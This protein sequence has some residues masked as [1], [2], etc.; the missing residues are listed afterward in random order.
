[1]TTL[2]SIPLP[3]LDPV[4]AAGEVTPGWVYAVVVLGLFVVTFLLWLSMRKQLGRIRFTE[5][6]S[7]TKDDGEDRSESGP[8]T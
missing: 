3:L 4:P 5:D 7:G 1:M 8:G 2:L 6:G